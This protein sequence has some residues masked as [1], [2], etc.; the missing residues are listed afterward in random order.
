MTDYVDWPQSKMDDGFKKFSIVL[1][2]SISPLKSHLSR[3]RWNNSPVQVPMRYLQEQVT[4]FVDRFGASTYL[5]LPKCLS[6][7]PY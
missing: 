5:G 2:L 7:G 6:H 1:F 4:P 3:I